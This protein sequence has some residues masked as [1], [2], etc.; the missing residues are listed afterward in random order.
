MR[1]LTFGIALTILGIIIMAHAG[2]SL[3]SSKRTLKAHTTEMT[4]IKSKVIQLAPLVGLLF[5]V[6]GIGFAVYAKRNTLKFD[7]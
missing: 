2:S 6:G 7:F 5:F 4:I 1:S 3:V